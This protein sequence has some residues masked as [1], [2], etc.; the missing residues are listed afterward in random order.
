M[1]SESSL[2]WM[3]TAIERSWGSRVSWKS[4]QYCMFTL[5]RTGL[6]RLVCSITTYNESSPDARTRCEFYCLMTILSFVEK[7]P[8]LTTDSES[9]CR[10][11]TADVNISITVECLKMWLYRLFVEC[12]TMFHYIDILWFVQR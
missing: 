11:M 4:K 2:A 9:V 10:W 5:T 6:L 12:L 8:I 1:V 3:D 7:V